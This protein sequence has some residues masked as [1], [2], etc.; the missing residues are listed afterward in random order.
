MLCWVLGGLGAG[1]WAASY[2]CACIAYYMSNV[3]IAYCVSMSIV[4]GAGCLVVYVHVSE[5]AYLLYGMSCLLGCWA[6]SYAC[7]CIAYSMSNVHIAYCMS[8]SIV[9]GA[10]CLVVYVHVSEVAYLLHGMSC[11]LGCWAAWLLGVGLLT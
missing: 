10:G 4:W 7:A 2:A 5:V 3:H 1:C 11:L 6:A 9:R 8:M